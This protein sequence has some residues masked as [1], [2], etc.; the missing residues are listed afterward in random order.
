MVECI[1]DKDDVQVQFLK[2]LR[3]L[4]EWFKVASLRL[5]MGYT[6]MGSNPIFS[7]IKIILVTFITHYCVNIFI[8]YI[9]I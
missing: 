9:I 5:V 2:E 7:V 6:I 8:R 1:L 4:T 3:E